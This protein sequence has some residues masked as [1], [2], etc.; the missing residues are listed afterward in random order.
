MYKYH[1]RKWGIQKNL[2]AKQ[3]RELLQQTRQGDRQASEY[4]IGG[5]RVDQ[6]R[7][8]NLLKR[9]NKSQ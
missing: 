9:A 4:S 5:I 1:L 6:E 8:R 2:R 3:A 7:L